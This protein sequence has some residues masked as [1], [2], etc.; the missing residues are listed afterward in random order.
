MFKRTGCSL[1]HSRDAE[2]ALSSYLAGKY[3]PAPSPTPLI[4]DVLAAYGAEHGTHTLSRKNLGYSLGTLLKYWSGKKVEDITAKSCREYSAARSIGGARRDLE[5]LRAAVNYWHR[6]YGP[7]STVPTVVLPTKGQP[8]E[9]WLTRGEAARL[10]WAA[11]RSRHLVRFML[12]GLYT[13]SRAGVMFKLEWSWVDFNSGIMRRRAPGAAESNKRTPPV[14]LGSRILSHL[15]RWHRLDKG[16]HKYVVR[17]HGKPVHRIHQSWGKMVK[18]AGLDAAV[19]PHTLRHT[20]ATWLMQEGIDPW[21]AAQHLGMSLKIL[22]DV[23]GHHHPDF[24]KEAS[25]V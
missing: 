6:E 10:L 21:K 16:E 24:Q 3:R 15:R 5:T 4:D 2:K 11:R 1:E 25:E 20:R 17:Y 7:L 13:G 14:R 19:T 12:L 18:S 23:Y 9:R 22:T 8:K